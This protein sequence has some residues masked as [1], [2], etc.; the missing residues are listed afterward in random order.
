VARLALRLEQRFGRLQEAAA[1]RWEWR[2]PP[3]G[4]V[5]LGVRGFSR[6]LSSGVELD[7]STHRG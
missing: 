6:N 5:T 1:L 3:F 2:G 4:K 7:D